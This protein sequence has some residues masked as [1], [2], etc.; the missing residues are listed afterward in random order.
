MTVSKKVQ[1]FPIREQEIRERGL[2]DV[3]RQANA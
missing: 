1:K 3:A 2:E